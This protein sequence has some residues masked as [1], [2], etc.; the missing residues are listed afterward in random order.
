MKRPSNESKER[1]INS[2]I[3]PHQ[4]DNRLEID[5]PYDKSH[6]DFF[7]VKK[8]FL[9]F[10]IKY[11]KQDWMKDITE[12]DLEQIDKEF[13]RENFETYESDVI[14]KIALPEKMIQDENAKEI[15]VF[16]IQEMQSNNDYTMP[17]RLL[18]Y[19]FCL[20][21]REFKNMKNPNIQDFSLPAIIPCVFYNGQKPWKAKRQFTDIIQNSQLLGE[22]GLNFKYILVDA[23][24]L[25]KKM[26]LEGNTPADNLVYL[27]SLATKEECMEWMQTMA[28]RI[29]DMP[30]TEKYELEKWIMLIIGQRFGMQIAKEMIDCM[31]KGDVGNM[32]TGLEQVFDMEYTKGLERGREQGLEQGLE[33]GREEAG[34]ETAQILL[35]EN[36]TISL[37]VKATKLSKETVENI[38]EKMIQEGK[39]KPSKGN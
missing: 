19:M 35:L 27:D 3:I 24:K 16:L 7:S 23:K 38:R 32:S 29:L 15:Y 18:A 39:L 22:W 14:Y 10:A 25:S 33:R 13:I 17:F 5:K 2:E 1:R 9:D 11:L 20:W 30:D 21:M 36:M 4:N 6:K 37:I 12:E 26:I 8:N 28:K 31:Q 34:I